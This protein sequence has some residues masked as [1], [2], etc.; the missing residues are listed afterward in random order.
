[1][2]LIAISSSTQNRIFKHLKGQGIAYSAKLIWIKIRF[3]KDMATVTTTKDFFISYNHRDSAWAE[4]IAWQLEH[5]GYGTIIQSWDFKVGS[6][7][8]VQMDK[9]LREAQRLIAVLSPSYFDSDFTPP[10]WT[11]M[12]VKD[13]TGAERKLIP[14]RVEELDPGGLLSAVVYI[15][16]VGKD[17]TA[18]IRELLSKVKEERPKPVHAPTF[19]GKSRPSFPG[20]SPSHTIK[21]PEVEFKAVI[22]GTVTAENRPVIEAIVEHLRK[23]SGDT[24]LTLL[25]VRKGS[26]VLILRCRRSGFARLKNLY[27]QESLNAAGFKVAGLEINAGKS[28]PR[29]I[30]DQELI[31]ALGSDSWSVRTNAILEISKFGAKAGPS[32]ISTLKKGDHHTVKSAMSVLL[33]IGPAIVPTL[34]DALTNENNQVRESAGFVLARIGPASAEPVPSLATALQRLRTEFQ[35]NDAAEFPEIGPEA[36]V[37]LLIYALRDSEEA[38]RARAAW[39]LGQIGAGAIEVVPALIVALQDQSEAVR[40]S[41]GEALATIGTKAVPALI[42]ALGDENQELRRSA[43]DALV[44]VGTS[45]VPALIVALRD[46]DFVVR[47]SSVDL[48]GRLGSGAAEA[49]TA[50]IAAL[51][52]DRMRQKAAYALGRIGPAAEEAVPAL[53]MA[54]RNEVAR[55]AAAYALTRMRTRA[56][57]GLIEALSDDNAGVRRS[58][59]EALDLIG[60]LTTEAVPDSAVPTLIAALR[61]HDLVV[62]RTSA[63]LLR[64]V[65]PFP[66]KALSD[67]IAAFRDYDPGVRESAA[68]VLQATGRQAVPALIGALGDDNDAVRQTAVGVLGAIGPAAA[69]AIPALVGALRDRNNMVRQRAAKALGGLSPLPVEAVHA[70]IT[71]LSD[72]NDALRLTAAQALASVWPLPP[73]AAPAMIRSLRDDSEEVRRCAALALVRIG[74]DAVHHLITTLLDAKEK[75][76]V[77]RI[78]AD[79]LGMIGPAARLAVPALISVLRDKSE[80]MRTA[81]ATALKRI[82]P[83]S[84]NRSVLYPSKIE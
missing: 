71:A 39:L 7:F 56:V 77:R 78:S 24:S 11:A 10:E 23:I 3:C 29:D 75:E 43:G 81:A 18:A 55:P 51:R 79:T 83:D 13:P 52:D 14:V 21:E 61:G 4:W 6:N 19:P 34:L 46:E 17:E 20:L 67:L 66:E 33:Q 73:D 38:V 16:L 60:Q 49:V 25:E 40:R 50:L 80:P 65:T 15:D 57:P 76:V 37:F 44:T 82:E 64:R 63:N 54:L 74:E 27:D 28:E 22:T 2:R 1:V 26:V 30:V 42:A 9:A 45:A 36:A 41:A 69:E 62:R 53:I 5:A 35:Q 72:D 12:F 59:A 47:Q 84:F 68:D 31:N 48:L 58:A 70:L 32:L 8:V